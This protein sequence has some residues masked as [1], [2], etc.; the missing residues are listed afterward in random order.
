[1]F[2]P[3]ARGFVLA[4]GCGRYVN[5]DLC[6][7]PLCSVNFAFSAQASDGVCAVGFKK[8]NIGLIFVI[9]IL[10]FLS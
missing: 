8:L 10:Q 5:P 9:P 4:L 6:S 2:A 1:M 3:K 7:L